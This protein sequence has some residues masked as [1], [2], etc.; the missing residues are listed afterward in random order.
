MQGQLLSIVT[1]TRADPAGLMR[2][3]TSARSWRSGGCVEQIVVDGGEDSSSDRFEAVGC[4]YVK[5]QS[6]CGIAAAFNEGISAARGEW[7]WFLN[8]GDRADERCD[9]DLVLNLLSVSKADVVICGTTYDGDQ[10]PR[11]FLPPKMQFPPILSWIPHPSAF[12]RRRLFVEFGL[13][14]ERYAIAMDYEWWLRA[15]S[16][17][18]PVDLLRIPVARFDVTGS[19]MRPDRRRIIQSETAHAIWRHKG[20]ILRS[21]LGQTRRVFR[22]T[23]SAALTLLWNRLRG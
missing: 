3:L 14:D 18:R 5:Q 15:L 19:S 11:P 9:P 1:I 12:I 17:E 8:G 23:S 22:E 13:F 10:E 21:W 6:S 4:R 7:I 16:R 2:T 20:V